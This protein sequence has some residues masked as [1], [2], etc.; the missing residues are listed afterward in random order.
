MTMRDSGS[1]SSRFMQLVNKATEP[2]AIQFNIYEHS[3]DP[4]GKA[5]RGRDASDQFIIY[6]HQVIMMP[7]DEVSV[8]VVWVGESILD[9]E[10]A[11]T[12]LSRQIPIPREVTVQPDSAD[13]LILDI[14]FLMNYEGRVY[15]TPLGAKADIITTSV[16]QVS[17]TSSPEIIEIIFENQGTAHI[18]MSNMSLVFVP[19]DSAGVQLKEQSIAIDVAKIPAMRSHLLAGGKRRLL[20][21]RPEGLQTGQFDVILSQ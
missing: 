13:K 15:I 19:L 21:P 10:Q 1:E 4:D 11:F 2:A 8:Q 16:N 6:P 20:I 7:G 12:L 14:R 17:G 9:I 18:S 5:I 3:K